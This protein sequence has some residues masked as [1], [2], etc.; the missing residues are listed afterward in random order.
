MTEELPPILTIT[1]K[2]FPVVEVFGPTIQ[3]EGSLAG[4]VSHFIR[5]GGCD[6]SCVW[7]DSAHAVLPENVR[8]VPKLT[9]SDILDRVDALPPAE[10]VTLSGGNPVLHELGK[11]VTALHDRG[12][13][14]AVETQGSTWKDWL[15]EVDM[16]TVSVKPPS[17]HMLNMGFE[18]FINRAMHGR[19]ILGYTGIC[20][21]VPVY[22][23]ADL[24]FA[25]HLHA[26]Y[27]AIP[28]YVSIVTEMGGLFGDFAGGHVDTAGDL[29]ARYNRIAEAVL[30]RPALRDARVIPQLHYLL[31][32]NITGV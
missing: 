8:K 12:Y 1:K 7:C 9:T 13:K 22:D 5:F 4:S 3:G 27:S 28:F 26:L 2:V 10:W 14:V 21:K 29:L 17:S 6:F 24:D 20:F 19:V 31:W 23:E 32:G 15:R 18:T 30:R 25:E 16:L 11:L